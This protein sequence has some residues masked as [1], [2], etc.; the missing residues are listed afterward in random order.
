[1]P[2]LT[3]FRLLDAKSPAGPLAAAVHQVNAGQG[4]AEVFILNPASF[5]QVPNAPFAYWVEEKVRGLFKDM[6][7]FESAGRT[8]RQG[9]AT[10]DDNRFVR[11]WWEP[12]AVIENTGRRRWWTFAKGGAFSPYYADLHLLV[13]WAEGGAEVKQNIIQ[14]YPYLK[15]NAGF[16]AKNTDYYFRHGLTWP[17]RTNGLSFRLLPRGA[18]FAHKGPA[19]FIENDPL[20]ACALVNSRCFGYLVSVQLA[21]VELAQSFEVGIIQNTPIPSYGREVG[22]CLQNITLEIISLKRRLDTLREN[23]HAFVVPWH[24]KR[25]VHLQ[26]FE[27]ELLSFRKNLD[28]CLEEKQTEIERHAEELYAFKAPSLVRCVEPMSE[29]DEEGDDSANLDAARTIVS[30]LTGVAFG[31]WAVPDDPEELR[32]PP[33]DPFA[34]LPAQA[35]GAAPVEAAKLYF[36][37]DPS[38]ESTFLNSCREALRAATGLASV[39]GYEQDLAA[40]LG[41]PALRDY[42]SRPASFFADHLSVYSKSRRKAPIYWPLS[43]RSGDFV[44]WVYYPKLEGDSLTRLITEVLDPRLRRLNE[45]LGALAA[46]GGGAGRKAKLESLRLELAEMR[47]DF[48]ELIAKGYKPDLNDGVLITACPL[49]KYFRHAGFRKNLEACWKELARGDYDWAHLAMSMWPE[50]LLAACKK[51]RSIAI[52]HGREDLCPA[53]QPK[54]SRGRKKKTD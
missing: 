9:L 36:A 14:R 8:A 20:A 29:V 44:I 13:N 23:S 42:F 4:G 48:Q 32:K 25:L 18:I 39:D 37:E 34:P 10:T 38:A 1:M 21:R 53:E 30:Y 54:A 3:C 2:E 17:L 12:P 24:G 22:V 45:E 5:E 31:R 16:V 11:C 28:R 6:T 35:P 46:E 40:R 26:L 50:R 51:D 19:A 43:T 47:Q 15:G 33:A 27:S 7:H 49:A 52:A 41:V